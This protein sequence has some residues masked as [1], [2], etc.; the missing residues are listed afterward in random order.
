[1][2]CSII[3]KNRTSKDGRPFAAASAK[4]KYFDPAD[5]EGLVPKMDETNFY[6]KLTRKS[7]A[8][9]PTVDGVYSVDFEG[10]AWV[11]LREE[12]K[13]ATIWLD[14]TGFKF[15]KKCDLKPID[16]SETKK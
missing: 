6:V 1:M 12:T 7:A 10:S 13:H 5:V 16:E 2:H 3:V 8:A 11:D 14:G 15:E 9:Y 4:G